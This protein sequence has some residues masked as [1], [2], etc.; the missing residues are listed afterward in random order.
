M[1]NLVFALLL[2]ITIPVHA[3]W[4]KGVTHVHSLWSDGDAAPEVIAKWYKDRGYSFVMFSEHNLMQTGDRWATIGGRSNLKLEHVDAIRTDFGA[5]WPVI[6]NAADGHPEAM[7]LRTFDELSAHF[8]EAGKFL[9]VPG[10][11]MTS[12]KS[13]HTNAVNIRDR[14]GVVEG[15]TKSEIIEAQVK[16][17]EAQSAKYN[18]P[19][20]AHLNHINWN[21]AV[22]TEEVL[23]APSLRFIEIYNGHPGTHPWGRANDGMPPYDE[24]WD[25]IQSTRLNRDPQTPLLYG[26]ATDDSH[27]YHKWGLGR[28]NPGRGWVMVNATDLSADSLV[29]ALQAGMFYATTGTLLDAIEKTDTSLSV[30]IA[31]QDGVK[32]RTVFYG[33][34]AGF[35]T[36]TSQRTDAT[37]A[38]PARAS[39]KY[40]SEIG[41]VLLETTDNPAVYTFKGD[42]LYVRARVYSDK[43]QEN[44]IGEG[45]LETAWV[46]PVKP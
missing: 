33:T 20:I 44:P 46:E 27:D 4:Y 1:R 35:D 15:A 38:V 5:D 30:T 41:A 8:N 6:R 37:G 43:L 21:E 9:L 10:E 18:Q 2:F 40:S 45:D 22:T 26:M 11:E 7:R 24:H 29:R 14:I 28:V 13:V 39:L 42:E 25:N 36:A 17:V 3:E 16:L 12:G 23:G 32:Y 31:A 34:R 19:M